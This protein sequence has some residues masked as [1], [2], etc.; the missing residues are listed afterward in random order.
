MGTEEGFEIESRNKVVRASKRG[1][2]DRLTIYRILDESD[3]ALVSFAENECPFSIPMLFARIENSLIFHGAT[4]SRLM[5]SMCSGRQLCIS[6]VQVNGIVL[7][8][9]LFHHSMNYESVVSYGS[10]K[11]ITE[12]QSKME[13]LKQ[14]SEKVMPGRWNDSR[15]PNEK[16]MKATMLVSVEIDSASAKIREGEPIDDD[17]DLELP[18]WS[19]TVDFSKKAC[20]VTAS[21][22]SIKTI[23][24]YVNEYVHRINAR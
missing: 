2:Y 19:G 24:D 6:T 17:E 21:D 1:K 4:T 11:E 13:A 7:A 16:E 22:S 5:K 23:P 8:R 3:F 12:T 10:G 9:S 15:L 18:Y 20:A 14:I